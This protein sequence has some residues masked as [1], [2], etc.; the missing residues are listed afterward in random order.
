MSYNDDK[1]ELL[2]LK[3]GLIEESETIFEEEKRPEKYE[4]HGGK[5]KVSNFFYHYKWH[6]IVIA[7]FALVLGFLI[8]TTVTKE[9]K[10]IRV[11]LTANDRSVASSMYFKTEKIELALEQ[12]CPDFDENGNVH[13]EVYYIDMVDDE[14]TA[15]YHLS[16]QAKLFGEISV[17]EAHIFIANKDLIEKEFVGE[18]DYSAVLVNLS[19]LYPDDPNIVDG[20]FYRI[21]GTAFADA[22]KY[23]ETC[24]EDM[25]IVIRGNFNG[26]KQLSGNELE[27]HER[28]LEVFDN[29]IKDN[30]VNPVTEE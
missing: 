18:N 26:M 11:L 13:A 30:K 2:K 5:A 22:A 24:P 8:Y 21:K 17:A 19:E 23:V 14:N 9:Q 25:Y 29:I 27:Q 16:N 7:F 20:Y 3:Q 4:I 10:D 28:A 1:R 12:Y 6:V 15:S